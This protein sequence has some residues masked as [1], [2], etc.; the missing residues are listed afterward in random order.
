[1]SAG[2]TVLVAC[3]V[4]FGWFLQEKREKN[5]FLCGFYGFWLGSMVSMEFCVFAMVSMV[6]LVF[7][8]VSIGFSYI[9]SVDVF[10]MFFYGFYGIFQ[11]SLSVIYG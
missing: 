7:P 2:Q 5:R 4:C 11:C 3:G 9:I 10:V 1:M 6:F 8:L